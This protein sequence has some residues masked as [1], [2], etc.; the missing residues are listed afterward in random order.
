MVIASGHPKPPADW[1]LWNPIFAADRP[2]PFNG[3]VPLMTHEEVQ[4]A[5]G[6]F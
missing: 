5:L 3:C 4:A 6:V 1:F 2:N